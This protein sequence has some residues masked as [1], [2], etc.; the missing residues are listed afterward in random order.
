MSETQ[1]RLKYKT[2]GNTSPQEKPRVYFCCHPDDFG[3]SFESISNEILASQNC[4]VWYADPVDTPRDADLLDDLSR[5]Q[6]FV[7]PITYRLLHT[8]NHAIDV[9][10]RFAA[11][12]N[13]PILP[14]MQKSGLESVFNR[15][16][17]NIQYLDPNAIDITAI[18]YEKKI[19]AFLSSV[20]VGD[21]LAEKIRNAFDAYIF[22]S[23]RKKER[24]Y[25]QEL[26]RLIH[27]NEFCRDIAIWYDEFLTPR[28]NFN[29][30]IRQGLDNSNLFVMTVTPSL[31]EDKNY[32][33]TTEYPMAME[34]G[35]KIIPPKW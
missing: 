7:I 6:L 32:V 24:K 3:R 20:L 4:S 26:M 16:C 25:A 22:L 5:M 19:N 27:Q 31:V 28:G 12:R 9:E 14:L 15:K 2:R 8:K 29:D 18:P 30:V 1:Y 11:E 35:K 33:M 34:A 10:F 13:I 23:Y 17:G 21:E